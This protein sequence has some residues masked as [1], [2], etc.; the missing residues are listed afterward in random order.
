[1]CGLGGEVD[2]AAVVGVL[3][4]FWDCFPWSDVAAAFAGGRVGRSA[5]DGV[6]LRV[7]RVRRLRSRCSRFAR[8]IWLLES[9]LT[10]GFPI[11]W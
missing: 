5:V 11:L 2:V 8:R 9:F 6:V 1:V 4:S 10:R 3:G 7:L